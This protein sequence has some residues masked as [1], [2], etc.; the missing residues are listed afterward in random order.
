MSEQGPGMPSRKW[1]APAPRRLARDPLLRNSFFLTLNAGTQAA[2]SFVFWLLNSHLLLGRPN[3]HGHDPALRCRYYL[4]D[5]PVWLQQHVHS[6]PAR[7]S[8]AETRRS[9]RAC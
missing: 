6:V 8:A 2:V 9:T 1:T 3:R 7:L 5:Q 4:L